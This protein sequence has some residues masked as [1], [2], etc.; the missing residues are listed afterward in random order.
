MSTSASVPITSGDAT[1]GKVAVFTIVEASETREM[2]RMVLCDS[3]GA[4]I[5]AGVQTPVAVTPRANANGATPSRVVASVTGNTLTALKNTAGNIVNI[6]LFNVAT[7]MV[8]LK[9]YNKATAVTVGTDTPVWTIP[10]PAGGSFSKEFVQGKSFSAG[11]AFAITKL[12]ADTDTTALVAGDVT[13]SIDW[14]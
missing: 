8:F 9:F 13:G 3:T 4:E 1:G 11:I 2:Q 12:Q 7:Y 14:I 5:V 6:D 10:I